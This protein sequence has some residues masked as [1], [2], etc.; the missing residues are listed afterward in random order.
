MV[1]GFRS[2]AETNRRLAASYK[3]NDKI[4]RQKS[5]LVNEKQHAASAACNRDVKAVCLLSSKFS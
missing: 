1:L 5:H 4:A 2:L 3:E